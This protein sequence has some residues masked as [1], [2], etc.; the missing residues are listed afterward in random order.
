MIDYDKL[1][2]RF[3]DHPLVRERMNASARYHAARCLLLEAQ[4]DKA[5]GKDRTDLLTAARGEA[6]A[7][8]KADS[9]DEARQIAEMHRAMTE[10]QQLDRDAEDLL[11]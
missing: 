4:A 5:R 11:Q 10:R 6:K 9:M 3:G 1:M 2:E 7:A 8:Y